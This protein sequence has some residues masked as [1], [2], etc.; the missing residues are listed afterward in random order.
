MRTLTPVFCVPDNAE[1]R[2]YW[3]RVQD[4]LDKLRNCMDI[5]GVRRLPSLF[6]PPIDP[7]LLVRLR[8][9]GLSLEEVRGG[10]PGALPPYRFSYVIER[11]KAMASALQSIGGALLG[12]LER[13]SFS[14]VLHMLSP[15]TRNAVEAELRERLDR[16]HSALDHLPTRASVPA[17]PLAEGTPTSRRTRSIRSATSSSKAAR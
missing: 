16:L 9:A 15:A 6:D 1:L 13:R 17:A 8:A 12:A 11:A 10:G 3:T 14:A 2:G 5:Q 4:R 7:R